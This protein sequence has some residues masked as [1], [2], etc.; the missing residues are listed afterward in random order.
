LPR[1]L[2]IVG[3]TA[4]G[5]TEVALRLAEALGGEIISADS[6]QVYTMMDIGTAKA[7]PEERRRIPHHLVDVL[8][9]DEAFNAGEFAK[10]GR[11]IVAEICQRSRVPI[12]A[13]GSG[14]YVR[15]LVDGLF[16]GPSADPGLRRKW[17][18]RLRTEGAETLLD[19]L[20]RIDPDAAATMLPSN[21]RRI[22]RAL[23]VHELSGTPIS[24][25]QQAAVPATFVP[26]LSGLA[27]ERRL[28]YERINRRV[29]AMLAQGLLEEV[30]ALRENGYTPELNAL[31]TVGYQEVF[32]YLAGGIT[33]ERMVEL[34]KMNT[35]RF[36]KRQLT[37]F[38]PDARI[39][40]YS[41][42][43]EGDL[44]RIASLI[45]RDFRDEGKH[46]A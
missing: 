27:W 1:A 41:V 7:S 11:R 39:R 37:W 21:T 16:E 20:R 44:P 25:L 9:P 31:Q 5:K 22:V 13:G 24:K 28:L 17:N 33:Y 15:A 36:A 46:P 32:A 34:M 14:L 12:I 29:D 42:E 10:R 38:R 3:P 18:E 2:V 23:E 40:W 19:E 43:A 4:S 35:R 8:P 6:R 45:A 30:K 26:F